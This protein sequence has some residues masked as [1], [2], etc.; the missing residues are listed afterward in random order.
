MTHNWNQNG[1]NDKNSVNR[2]MSLPFNVCLASALACYEKCIALLK[3]VPFW[4]VA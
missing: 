2:L 3:R 1:D 4:V